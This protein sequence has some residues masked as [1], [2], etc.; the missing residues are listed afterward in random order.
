MS[1]V[2]HLQASV[3]ATP[4]K[5]SIEVVHDCRIVYGCVPLS[6]MAMLMHGMS[7]H[8]LMDITTADRIGASMVIGEPENLEKLRAANL[9]PSER[10]REEFRAA[11]GLNLPSVAQWLLE[12]E[13]GRSSNAMCKRMYGVPQSAGTDH[14]HDPSDLLRCLRFLDATDSH[15]KVALMADVSPGWAALVPEWDALAAL[16]RE[17][18][19]AGNSAPKTYAAMQSCL[20]A[21]V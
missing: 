4:A 3:A 15:A 18:F 14:P 21:R 9:P 17:E 6:Q 10:R 1:D 8:A 5:F 12:G 16:V 7:K 13:R 2:P 20:G 11:L 19:G